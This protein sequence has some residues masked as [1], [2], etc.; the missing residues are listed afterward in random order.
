MHRDEC[1]FNPIEFD[2][3]KLKIDILS[4]G[5]NF[6]YS[7]GE[8]NQFHFK[9]L[10]NNYSTISQ[11][12]DLITDSGYYI[13]Y[14]HPYYTTINNS[15]IQKCRNVKTN[16]QNNFIYFPILE[17][18]YKHNKNVTLHNLKIIKY[19]NLYLCTEEKI[20][21]LITYYKNIIFNNYTENNNLHLYRIN[22]I[23]NWIVLKINIENNK[24]NILKT[25]ISDNIYYLDEKY[26]S[27]N[28]II[29]FTKLF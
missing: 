10:D 6:E 27:K 5:L 22:K 26:I 21:N 16:L 29:D 17:K 19:D 14:Y 1:L 18:E 3:L 15:Y 11:F 28:N 8:F 24:T 9:L 4:K 2:E 23:D 20:S 13:S 25:E 7:F 12:Y